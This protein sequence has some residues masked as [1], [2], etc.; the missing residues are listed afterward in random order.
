[1]FNGL[2][3]PFNVDADISNGEKKENWDGNNS[4]MY[5]QLAE[6]TDYDHFTNSLVDFS[7]RL[8]DEE[9]IKSFLNR[10]TYP[11]NS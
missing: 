7:K 9:K 1:M 2:L 5:V 6:G 11:R 3:D 8:I 10:L 4:Y